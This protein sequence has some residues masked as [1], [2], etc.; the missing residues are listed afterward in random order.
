MKKMFMFLAAFCLTLPL[1]AQFVVNGNESAF[2]K[3]N[4]FK[5]NAY[6]FIY[7]AGCDSLAYS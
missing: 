1:Y 3:W 6:Q 4:T 5:T 2:T 7:P